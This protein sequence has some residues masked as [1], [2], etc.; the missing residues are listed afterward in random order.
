[1][2]L[3]TIRMRIAAIATST[4]ALLGVGGGLAVSSLAASSP[5]PAT[6][7][8]GCVVGTNRVLQNVYTNQANYTAF[9]DA[10][11]GKCPSGFAVTVNTDTGTSTPTPTPTSTTPAPTTPPATTPPAQTVVC[12]DAKLD[13]SACGPFSD[14]N[15][16]GGPNDSGATVRQ[17]V[18]NPQPQLTKQ[19]T[20]VFSGPLNFTSTIN[21]AKGN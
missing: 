9:L 14:P 15:V 11:G 18:W 20:K 12:E 1:M 3:M 19:D 2:E 5:A 6:N 13:R 10:N 4:V 17:E 8:Y 7:L 21:A 16:K